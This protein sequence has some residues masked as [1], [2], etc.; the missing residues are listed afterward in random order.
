MANI[1]ALE[2][3]VTDTI[4]EWEMKLGAINTELR[5]YYPTVSLEELLGLPRECEKN[6]R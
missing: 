1:E 3:H 2:R 4:K 6:C 5:L